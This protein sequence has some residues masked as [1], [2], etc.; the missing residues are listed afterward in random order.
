MMVNLQEPY[1][2]S[3]KFLTSAAIPNQLWSRTVTETHLQIVFDFKYPPHP[4]PA[5]CIHQNTCLAFCLE[6]KLSPFWLINIHYFCSYILCSGGASLSLSPK[7]PAFLSLPHFGR[8]GNILSPLQT[9]SIPKTQQQQHHLPT[10]PSQA[11]SVFSD[12]SMPS[13]THTK[14]SLI[15]ITEHLVI[16]LVR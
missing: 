8:E 10:N 9:F 15:H 1:T 14:L 4:T 5:P 2:S 11:I 12:W 3:C 16:I 13:G 6:K 7:H